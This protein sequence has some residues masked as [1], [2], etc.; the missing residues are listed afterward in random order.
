MSNVCQN[1]VKYTGSQIQFIHFIFFLYIARFQSLLFFY[2][3]WFCHTFALLRIY[4]FIVYITFIFC[5]YCTCTKGSERK[6]FSIPLYVWDI[7]RID[8][9]VD[10]TKNKKLFTCGSSA[11]LNYAAGLCSHCVSQCVPFKCISTAWYGRTLLNLT[12]PFLVS[13]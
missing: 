12:R 11:E 4:L 13:L 2:T 7:L 5:T 9:K 3:V 8:N 6:V 10:L 1:I